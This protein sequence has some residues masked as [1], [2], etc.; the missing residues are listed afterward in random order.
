MTPSLSSDKP[1]TKDPIRPRK[2][3][4]SFLYT[5]FVSLFLLFASCGPPGSS[6]SAGQSSLSVSVMGGGSPISGSSV[7]V[8]VSTDTIG[9]QPP[10]DIDCNQILATGTTD[11]NG[12]AEISFATPSSGV[13]Y[14]IAEGG[15][16]G[17]V[18]NP[19]IKMVSVL[20]T[21]KSLLSSV[22]VNEVTTAS[23]ASSVR[24]LIGVTLKNPLVLDNIAHTASRFTDFKTGSF[25][26][27]SSS[28]TG[29]GD[30]ILPYIANILATCVDSASPEKEC[31]SLFS[32]IRSD[33]SASRAPV[34]TTQAALLILS[35][36]TANY[37]NLTQGISGPFGSYSQ[38]P[39]F[40][41]TV[42]TVGSAYFSTYVSPFYSAVDQDGNVWVTSCY[43]SGNF[44][45]TKLVASND[46]APVTIYGNGSVSTNLLNMPV[47]PAIDSSGNVWISNS[48]AP[49][50]GISEISP[51]KNN[52]ITGF[53]FGSETGNTFGIAVDQDG[54][55]WGQT[56]SNGPNGYPLIGEVS[57]ASGSVST[58]TYQAGASNSGPDAM[59]IDGH[60]NV[61]VADCI[62][63]VIV[64]LVKT[65]TN[66]F[67]Y[68]AYT[69][70]GVLN[71]AGLAVDPSNNVWIANSDCGNGSANIMELPGGDPSSPVLFS[72]TSITGQANSYPVDLVSDSAGNIW[73]VDYNL[74]LLLELQNNSGSYSGVVAGHLPSGQIYPHG[75]SIDSNGNIWVTDNGNRGTN[76]YGGGIVEFV[77]MASPVKTPV[78]GPPSF[79]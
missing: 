21:G 26:S 41:P 74:D 5:P 75:I 69:I 48:A 35:N 22:V 67:S 19:Y 28:Q 50:S 12:E 2:T 63:N 31:P 53:P 10:P 62:N 79:P 43:G 24:S 3:R 18:N 49:A 15:N 25:I 77:G 44:A 38:P 6:S 42:L 70:S 23:F 56:Y 45:V 16:A 20:G 13:V 39:I 57:N 66:S 14:L 54:N 34:N 73:A 7:S 47:M 17:N 37:A 30:T 51:S 33:V 60:G 40:S 64:E 8:C 72:T 76:L 27:A 78:I 71:P 9:Q 1:F 55:V 36:P 52:R 46:Y 11:S 59:A 58:H 32:T 65:G 29:T 68:N 4:N 61:W